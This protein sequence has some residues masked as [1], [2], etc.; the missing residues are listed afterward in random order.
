MTHRASC[1]FVVHKETA[2]CVR[3]YPCFSLWR[4]EVTPCMLISFVL[5]VLR[6]CFVCFVVMQKEIAWCIILPQLCN[7]FAE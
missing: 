2:S 6:T 5:L 1:L 3:T 7:V 4:K